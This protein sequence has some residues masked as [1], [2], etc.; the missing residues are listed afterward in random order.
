M[1]LPPTWLYPKPK[2]APDPRI[3][4]ILAAVTG[5]FGNVT[6]IKTLLYNLNKK[7]DSIMV[8]LADIQTAETDEA[9]AI[10]GVVNELASL[11]S[12][13]AAAQASGADPATMQAIVDQ[14]HA[15]TAKLT[16]ALPPATTPPAA[17]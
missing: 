15:N 13:L 7:V 16:S 8:T 2:P 9:T 14:I 12:Q 3:D 6:D 11:E 17:A 10:T 1:K 4:Q 5:I